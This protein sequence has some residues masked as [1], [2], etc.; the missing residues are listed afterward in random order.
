MSGDI[1]RSLTLPTRSF[2]L[3]GPRGVGKS[4]WLRQ[5]LKGARVFDL[6][7]TGLQLELARA[8]HLL[9]A[10]IGATRTGQWIWIDEVQKVPALL[11]EVHRLMESRRLRFALSGSSARKLFRQGAD[12]LAGRAITRH[13]ESFSSGELGGE[14]DLD[15][16][17]RWGAL[18]LVTLDQENAVDILTAYVH[19]YI[20]E[21][22]REEG[23]VRKAEPF[24]RFLEVAG[25]MNAQ[26]LNAQN[27]AREAQVE[28]KSVVAYFQILEDTL[29]G[30]RLPAWQPQLKVRETAHPKFY[31]F[32]AGVARAAASL[33]RE[34][35]DFTWLGLSLETLLFHELRVYN[36][37]SGKERKLSYYRTR[38]GA[39]VDFVVE[40]HRQ[41][42]SRKPTVILIEAKLGKRWKRS[43]EA[44]MR[45]LM[46]TDKVIVAGAY[47]LYTGDARYSFEGI[48]VLP[49]SAFLSA[50]HAGQVF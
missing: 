46:Q 48:E 8:P 18:P 34:V 25:L 5:Q 10:M 37:A 29:V 14:F 2:F 4:Y 50:L 12:L 41:T 9:E 27:I 23:L 36:H 31:W 20:R 39:E 30:H 45:G 21:E 49:V 7:D 15:L 1:L 40:I 43:W 11:D 38:A 6:L 42:P 32:D 44:G 13:L 24:L 26:I 22:I 19:T 3:F 16:A 33:L 47:G 17:L 35:P 28:R